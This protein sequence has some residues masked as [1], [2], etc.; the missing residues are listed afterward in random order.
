MFAAGVVD[1]LASNA[2]SGE[3]ETLIPSWIWIEERPDQDKQA[4]G[5][6]QKRYVF[7][8]S[9]EATEPVRTARLRLAADFCRADIVLNGQHLTSVEPYSE[10]I[11]I[12][13]TNW[14]VAGTNTLRIET[15]TVPGPSALAFSLSL[16]VANQHV[17]KNIVSDAS[18]TCSA[19]SNAVAASHAE[20]MAVVSLGRVSKSFWGSGRRLSKVEA[21]ENYEQWRQAVAGSTPTDVKFW[22]APGFEIQLLRNA[23]PEE[24]SWVSMAFD[25]IGRLTVAREERGLLRMTISDSK[26]EIEQVEVVDDQLLECR[27]LLYAHGGLYANANDSKG[28]YRLRDTDGDDEFDEVRLL[29][30]FPGGV[31]HGRNDLALGPDGWI[32]S[33]HGDSVDLPTQEVVDRTSPFRDSLRSS[34]KGQGYLLRTDPEGSQWE[35]VCCGLRNPFGLSVNPQGDWFSYD[36]DAEFDMGTPWYRPTR[37]VQLRS[38]ADYGWRAVTGK[39]PPYFPDHVDNAMPAL[40]VGKGSPTAVL[41][42][43]NAKFPDDYRRALFILDWTYGRILAVHMVSRGAGYRANAETFLQGRPL[44]VTDLATGPDGALYV[45]TGGRKT[46]SSLYRIAYMN[47]FTD[48]EALSQHEQDCES[49]ADKVREIR[50]KLESMHGTAAA[51]DAELV[52]IHIDSPDWN[53]RYAARIALEHQ[54][55]E[56]WR[57]RALSEDRPQASIEALLALIRSGDNSSSSR[58]RDRLLPMQFGKMEL[59]Q[60][61]GAIQCYTLLWSF[62]PETLKI[63]KTE[64]IDQIRAFT[65]NEL[66]N[67]SLNNRCGDGMSFQGACALILADLQCETVIADVFSTLM[68]SSQQECRL[69]GLFA[70]RSVRG[71]WNETQRREYFRALNEGARFVRGE[72]M[73]KFLK[74][75]R[76]EAIAT[77]SETERREFAELFTPDSA[78]PEDFLPPTNRPIVRQWTMTDLAPA[79]EDESIRPDRLRGKAIF[80][81]AQCNRCHRSGAF[82]PAVGPD[83]THVANRFSLKDILRSII[84]PSQVIAENYRS[85]Q[86]LTTDGRVV[87]GRLLI[88]GDYRSQKLAIVS[89]SL[90]PTQSVEIDKSEIESL[91]ESPISPMPAGLLDTFNEHE[92]RDLLEYLRG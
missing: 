53:L 50:A 78:K 27:G 92:I 32:Y 59:S 14:I 29:R 70:L 39:W 68:S 69:S 43:T 26:R 11:D 83:L 10:T 47:D 81:D 64:I 18:W 22:T 74:Q 30:E 87:S 57:E 38:G 9:F 88:E 13:A 5:E 1:A 56:S 7:N 46:Q 31:G 45:I 36:A 82:G 40:D 21:T 75:I 4:A 73:E 15:R 62:S 72:G 6:A 23:Q 19:T 34:A 42:P 16:G 67:K 49:H 3:S 12:D 61:M 90:K 28:L 66:Y 91:T 76:D 33:I 80:D 51:F 85:I 84:E 79:L 2:T 8:R 41:F 44:N 86:I 35:V 77:L 37:V 52:W 20:S 65:Q 25:T 63:R 60:V 58:V 48:A 89:D 17:L 55:I 54:P 24:G 71:S